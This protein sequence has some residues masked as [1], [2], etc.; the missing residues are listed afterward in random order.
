M[1][2]GGGDCSNVLPSQTS[3]QGPV[4]NVILCDCLWHF[5]CAKSLNSKNF[6]EEVD[7]YCAKRLQD[8]LPSTHNKSQF[9]AEEITKVISS[10]RDNLFQ[11]LTKRESQGS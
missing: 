10:N 4:R 8:G 1:A 7:L 6:D 11:K 9:T 2:S 3:L 5:R